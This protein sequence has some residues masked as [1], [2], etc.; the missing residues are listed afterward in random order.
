ML[1]VPQE[2]LHFTQA[3]FYTDIQGFSIS[4][5]LIHRALVARSQSK[6]GYEHWQLGSEL[7]GPLCY[8]LTP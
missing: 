1:N 4:F 2:L 6:K 3:P 7:S 5:T 8:P